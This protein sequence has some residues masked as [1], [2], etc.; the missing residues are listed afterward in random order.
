[1]D[2]KQM[3]L[4]VIWEDRAIRDLHASVLHQLLEE[5][6]EVEFILIHS[7]LLRTATRIYFSI[8]MIVFL[9]CMFNLE[10]SFQ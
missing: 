6:G 8:Y 9:E 1:M 7:L 5:Q 10:K 4:A 2:V 3:K